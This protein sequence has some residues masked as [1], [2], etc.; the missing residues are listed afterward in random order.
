MKS[1]YFWHLSQVNMLWCKVQQH[2]VRQGTGIN[3]LV[4]VIL[5]YTPAPHL[6]SEHLAFFNSRAGH[7]HIPSYIT[8]T[9]HSTAQCSQVWSSTLIHCQLASSTIACNF[10][11]G[12]AVHMFCINRNKQ[13]PAVKYVLIINISCKIWIK[14]SFDSTIFIY[15]C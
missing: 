13:L 3:H 11:W 15:T 7:N 12:Y 5:S 6:R 4:L 14:F 9:D 2:E 10:I 1:A 8:H